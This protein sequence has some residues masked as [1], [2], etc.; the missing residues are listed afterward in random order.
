MLLA[1][2]I[3]SSCVLRAFLIGASVLY[4]PVEGRVARAADRETAE[5]EALACGPRAVFLLLRDVGSTATYSEVRKSTP[6]CERGVS[7][8]QLVTSIRS[9]GVP[10]SARR[11]DPSDLVSLRRPMIAYL[12]RLYSGNDSGHFVYIRSVTPE[13]PVVIDPVVGDLVSPWRWR[14][15]SDA[16]S[17]ICIVAEPPSMLSDP[18]L[19]IGFLGLVAAVILARPCSAIVRPT[20]RIPRF[21]AVVALCA[22]GQTEPAFGDER[23]PSET[24]RSEVRGGVNAAA[25]MLSCLTAEFPDCATISMN[26]PRASTS[27]DEV[28]AKLSRFGRETRLRAMTLAE[29]SSALPAIVLLRYGADSVGSYCLVL[30]VRDDGVVLLHTGP[31][32]ADVMPTD[33]F[34]ARWTG[35]ALI[36]CAM[37]LRADRA[38]FLIIGGV[39]AL[40]GLVL[41]HG[42]SVLHL[43]RSVSLPVSPRL[44]GSNAPRR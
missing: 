35:H 13:G 30:A 26:S 4:F 8:A 42:R 31:M 44:A 20:L 7:V 9:F 14:S 28:R 40:G 37:D 18:L 10:C 16:W 23:V 32:T 34:R 33:E 1:R 21:A 22:I 12:S 38:R 3:S 27:V 39:G 36:P 5:A 6:V 2:S 15:F 24:L 43:A 11:L 19:L 29:L 17:G 41:R 25:F